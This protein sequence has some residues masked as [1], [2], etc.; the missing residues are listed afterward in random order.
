MISLVIP[1]YN[2]Q[3]TIG[4]C[5][6]SILKQTYQDFEIIV[7]NDGSTDKTLDV[8]NKYRDRIKLF[9]QVN[10]GSPVA[11]NF[12][13]EKSC[14]EY[15]F[16]CDA[17][18]IFKAKALE[19]MVNL[20]NTRPEISYVYSAFRFGWKI[21]RLNAFDPEKLKKINYIST[22]SLIRK[23]DFPG[24]DEALKKFQDWDLW[25]TMLENDHI[26]A[27]IPEV[28]FRVQ[29]KNGGISS[30]LPS[31]MY[32]LRWFKNNKVRQYEEAR[33]VILKKHKLD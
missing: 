29:T 18:I 33:E 4:K 2:N 24:W 14:G 25:L 20:L 32:K 12:G 17:D 19:K 5:L 6:E 22:N 13:F 9:S 26:G 16:F 11:R 8:L 3:K 10:Q 27:W 30:W 7:I 23:R 31:F 21:F 28:L 15:I 1:T